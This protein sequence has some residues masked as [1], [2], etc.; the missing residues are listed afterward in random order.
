MRHQTKKIKFH[1]GQDSDTSIMKKL[2]YNFL[3]FNHI[4]TTERKAKALKMYMDRAISKTKEKTEANKNYLLSFFPNSAIIKVLF[5]QVGPAVAKING[6]FVKTTRINQRETDG[7]LMVKVQWAHPVV[8]DWG[9]KKAEVK[10]V[11]AAKEQAQLPAEKESKPKKK[12]VKKV[13]KDK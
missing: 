4:T 3:R 8:I 12:E 6:G 10:K 5:E 11:K 2:M 7:A 13:T 1:D 9:D